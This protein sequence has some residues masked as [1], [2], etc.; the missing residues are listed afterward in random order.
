[1]YSSSHIQS[2]M[3]VII[4]YRFGRGRPWVRW[5]CCPRKRNICGWPLKLH[6]VVEISQNSTRYPNGLGFAKHPSFP[7]CLPSACQSNHAASVC[8]AM[9]Q[10]VHTS[11][12]IRVILLHLSTHNHSCMCLVLVCSSVTL[13]VLRKPQC[14]Q[15]N[16]KAGAIQKWAPTDGCSRLTR[17]WNLTNFDSRYPRS[18]VFTYP[19]F[20][21]ALPSTCHFN[22][23]AS[24][25]ELPNN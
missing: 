22:N 14:K 17:C 18:P 20:V 6:K 3:Y 1:M 8:C 19:S 2:C 9:T 11:S 21:C 10:S 7:M 13:V 4:H 24:V 5:D 23:A 25:V 12:C 15:K 16:I